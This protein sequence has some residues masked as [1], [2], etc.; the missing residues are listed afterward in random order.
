DLL[1]HQAIR[2]A[3]MEDLA[4]ALLD[5]LTNS[6]QAS[7]MGQRARQVFDAQAGATGRTVRALRDLLGRGD[8][9]A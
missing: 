4:P 1:V 2:I 8:H 9:A 3:P 7:A 6:E 5:L